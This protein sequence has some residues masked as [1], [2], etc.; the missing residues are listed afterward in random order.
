MEHV[1]VTESEF[2]GILAVF[3]ERGIEL[4]HSVQDGRASIYTHFDEVGSVLWAI[5]VIDGE[6]AQ[7]PVITG[8]YA[9]IPR[10]MQVSGFCTLAINNFTQTS[11]KVEKCSDSEC[12][13]RF[14]GLWIGLHNPSYG[15]LGSCQISGSS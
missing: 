2:D 10:V 15:A 5:G 1:D 3:A 14:S 7:K 9:D 8:V 6:N 12:L 11:V 4:L 13:Q